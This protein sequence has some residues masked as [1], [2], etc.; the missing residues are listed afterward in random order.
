MYCC[1]YDREHERCATVVNRQLCH[2]FQAVLQSTAHASRRQQCNMLRAEISYKTSV[3]VY[4]NIYRGANERCKSRS[5]QPKP[6]AHHYVHLLQIHYTYTASTP[7]VLLSRLTTKQHE[8][9]YTPDTCSAAQHQCAVQVLGTVP[10]AQPL[11]ACQR[12]ICQQ[13]RYWCYCLL[14]LVAVV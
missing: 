1:V 12:C 2:A 13:Y 14:L 5:L 6:T 9:A 4:R 11:R 3:C 7:Y 8:T 10:V